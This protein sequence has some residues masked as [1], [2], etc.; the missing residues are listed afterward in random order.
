MHFHSER[1][2]KKSWGVEKSIKISLFWLLNFF[3]F[4][5]L[6]FI[7]LCKKLK[8]STFYQK[9]SCHKNNTKSGAT[10]TSRSIL[11]H[12]NFSSSYVTLPN[13]FF[14]TFRIY[15]IQCHRHLFFPM[16]KFILLFHSVL[17]SMGMWIWLD[18][19]FYFIAYFCILKMLVPSDDKK[20]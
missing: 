2:G 12:Y 5:Y 14:H 19:G 16:I 18:L 20:E 9:F 10:H 7:K 3:F 15:R 17:L 8:I 1:R 11:R 13:F 4:D 6:I